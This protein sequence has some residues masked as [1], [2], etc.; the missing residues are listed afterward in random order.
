MTK[1]PKLYKVMMFKRSNK[2][3][4][5]KII[6]YMFTTN[7]YEHIYNDFATFTTFS[8]LIPKCC[9]TVSPGAENPN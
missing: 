1:Y 9:M 8:A 4:K 3:M 2:F 6:N 7:F 5:D